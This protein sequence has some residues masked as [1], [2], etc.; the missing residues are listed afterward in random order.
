MKKYEVEKLTKKSEKAGYIGMNRFAAKSLRLPFKHKHPEHT[1][2]VAEGLDKDLRMRTIRHE[3]T[4]EYFM[5]NKHYSY[6][7]AHKLALKF[8]RK[9]MPFP[10]K[11]TKNVLKKIGLIKRG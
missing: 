10:R 9:H 2:E 4:E 3:E 6:K 8:E 1:I 5:K 7:K 11:N